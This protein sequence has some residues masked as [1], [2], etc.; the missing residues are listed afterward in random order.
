MRPSYFFRGEPPNTSLI[1]IAAKA[2]STACTC[3]TVRR[4]SAGHHRVAVLH[5]CDGAD[6]VGAAQIL[7]LASEIPQW[8]PPLADQ[9]GHHARHLLG[10]HFR[11]DAV[12]IVEIDAVDAQAAERLLR[13]IEEVIAHLHGIGQQLR[14]FALV[15]RSAVSVAHAHAAQPHG[16][17][18]QPAQT[19]Y[20]VLHR[21]QNWLFDRL[22]SISETCSL[23]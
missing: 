21:P 2:S 9:V 15:G 12:L 19:Q 17:D 22:I 7:L 20:S 13:R 6:L 1:G 11:V 10:L 23:R 4:M 18:P 5:G 14:H 16:G 8:S 3:A